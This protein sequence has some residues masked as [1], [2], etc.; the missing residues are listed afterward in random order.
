[1]LQRVFLNFLRHRLNK[2]WKFSEWLRILNIPQLFFPH[3]LIPNFSKQL[4]HEFHS[5][6]MHIDI[7]K[8]NAKYFEWQLDIGIRI[9]FDIRMQHNLLSQCFELDT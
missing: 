9:S 1:M 5:N 7:F 2:E 3:R 6:E 8:F 4:F